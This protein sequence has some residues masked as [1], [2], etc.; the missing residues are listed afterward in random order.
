MP[1]GFPVFDGLVRLVRG[2]RERQ[3][4]DYLL[5]HA[6]PEAS[7][8]DRVAWLTELMRW[9]RLHQ[10]EKTAAPTVDLLPAGDPSA[11]ADDPAAEAALS[12]S[13][14]RVRAARV[15]F[16]LQ[17][18]DRHPDWKLALAR[19]LRSILRDAHGLR[20]FAATGLPQEYGFWSEAARRIAAKLLPDPPA[21]D[22]L[23][24]VF[25][26]LFP[27]ID[28]DQLLLGLPL[29]TDAA[30]RALFRFGEP[31]DETCWAVVRRDLDDAV[32]VLSSQVAA[33]GISDAIRQRA[34]Y[35][36]LSGSPF[37]VLGPAAEAYIATIA[38]GAD[39]ARRAAAHARLGVEIAGCR[40]ALIDVIAHLEEN[41]VS[42]GLVYRIELARQQLDRI[43]ELIAL[44]TGSRFAVGEMSAF[45]AELIRTMHARRSVRS[46]FRT[47]L[48]LLTRK[49]AERTGK[50]GEHY[51]TR[52]RAEY[53]EMLRSA[54]KG[55]A[56]TGITVFA[57][58]LLTGHGLAPFFEGLVASFNYALSFCAIQ[59]VHGTLATKQP[60]MTAAAMA[61]KL[62]QA[63]HRGRLREFVDEVAN[64]TRSQVAAIAGNLAI[65][66]PAALLINVLWLVAT[67]V[68][69]PGPEKAQATIDSLAL[70]GPT[71]IYA[72]FTGV[73]L[74]G[75][76]ILSGWLEN[77]AVYRRLP[78]AIAHQPRLAYAF[79]AVRMGRVAA[80]FENNVAGLGGNIALGFMLG[81]TPVIAVFFGLPL[82]V[83]HVTLSTGSLALAASTLGIKVFTLPSF[84]LACAGIAVIGAM[85]LGVSFTLALLVAIRSTGTGRV[86]RRRV[87][88]AVFARFVA[89]PR[90]FLLPPRTA[91]GEK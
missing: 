80:W 49:I 82:D 36:E 52:D 48:F 90:D 65:V 56:L 35:G 34:G 69:V 9:I 75:S 47:N 60:A 55:G 41:G 6:D 88:R 71:P 53:V 5:A 61:S 43:E 13:T 40:L 91:A 78:E 17:L 79:G 20:L 76:A 72:A 16:L 89:A 67:G 31:A 25:L 10:P 23:S 57:K 50:T 54:G 28:N 51:I 58:F 32:V 87:L 22:D 21:G 64:L 1:R 68:R 12:G 63:R 19:T 38:E 18:L 45:V 26:A 84:W 2:P 81:M 15:R 73:L 46:L 14:L 62:K 8:P 85:N 30:L 66:I 4:L 3:A 70:L 74:W 44:A 7:L 42:V 29:E 11:A 27:E 86:S 37:V 24:R 39:E 33:I 59:F 83:R 77:W